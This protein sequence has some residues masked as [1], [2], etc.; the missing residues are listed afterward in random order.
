MI[1][2]QNNA[3]S[4][5]LLILLLS[6]PNTILSQL[7]TQEYVKELKKD[8][9]GPYKDI[10]WFCE[11]GS[12]R[13][14]R[15]PCPEPM[16]GVQHARYKDKVQSLADKHNLFLDQILVGTENYKF[17]DA[18]HDHSRLKQYQITN[19]LYDADTHC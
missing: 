18:A 10:K 1:K 12:I 9:R 15:D 5:L 6:I 19:F 14:A 11:D 4:Y 2:N 8:R 17:W 7:V 13:E 16:E 3:F